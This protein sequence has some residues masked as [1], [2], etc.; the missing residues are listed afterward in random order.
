[1]DWR[2]ALTVTLATALFFIFAL[3]MALKVRLTKPTTGQ[4]GLVGEQG[5]ALNDV[6]H[7][8]TVKVH[9]EIW[10]AVSDTPIKKGA[11]VAVVEVKGLVVKVTQI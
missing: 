4:E 10:K 9:G 8:G 7:E 1:V 2:V 3:S 11:T 5:V 6:Y